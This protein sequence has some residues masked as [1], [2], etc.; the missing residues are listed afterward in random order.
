MSKKLYEK[1]T[2]YLCPIFTIIGFFGLKIAGLINK[3]EFLLLG[4]IL[5]SLII[6]FFY[7]IFYKRN[8]NV[9]YLII[10]MIYDIILALV[11]LYKI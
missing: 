1:I 5:L 10:M 8:I 3:C 4:S 11:L 6:M 9:V 2:L 7:F